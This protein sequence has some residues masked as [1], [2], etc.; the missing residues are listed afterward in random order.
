[1]WVDVHLHLDAAAF[2]A[3]RDEVVA[4]AGAAGVGLMVSAGTSLEGSR[5]VLALAERYPTLRAAVG[6]HPASAGDAGP[7]DLEAL[8]E[9]VRHSRVV[10]VGEVGL[11]Y[12]RAGSPREVQI[13]IFRAQVRLARSHGLPLVVHN[14]GAH[15]D[16]GRILEE[17]GATLVVLHCF[18]GTPEVAIRW[19]EAGWMLSFAGPLTFANAGAL[20][21]VARA[22]PADRVLVETDAPYLAPAPFRGRRCEP[23]YLVHT[24]RELARLRGI[25]PD[26]LEGILEQNVRRLFTIPDDAPPGRRMS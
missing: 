2:D 16:V 7:S 11:D 17:E 8:S 19:A 22:V 26:R 21:E 13:E 6:I 18:S 5:R 15:E 14:R 12:V 3:D 25:P 23:A 24:A 4:R 20:R 10:A 9:L 1:M